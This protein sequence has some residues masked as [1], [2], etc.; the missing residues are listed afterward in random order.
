MRMPAR[1]N[2]ALRWCIRPRRGKWLENGVITDLSVDHLEP[3]AG[4]VPLDPEGCVYQVEVKVFEAEVLEAHVDVELDEARLHA[5]DGQ[6]ARHEEVP[7]LEPAGVDPA[8]EGLADGR[9]VLVEDGVVNEPD[10]GL[11]GRVHHVVG[12]RLGA[13]PGAQAG[14]G[15]PPRLLIKQRAVKSA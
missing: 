10:A 1:V 3:A 5:H 8:P 14:D 7:P 4:V 9:L 13:E 15:H 12:L 11:E 2:I 6:L